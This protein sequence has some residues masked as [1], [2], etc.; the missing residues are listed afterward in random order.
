VTSGMRMGER[1]EISLTPAEAAAP[2]GALLCRI[3]VGMADSKRDRELVVAHANVA[4]HDRAASRPT[5][6]W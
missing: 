1:R 2:A 3:D 5:A 4:A 6:A